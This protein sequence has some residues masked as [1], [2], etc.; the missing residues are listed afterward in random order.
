MRSIITKMPPVIKW[1]LKL[2]LVF[3]ASMTVFRFIFFLRYATDADKFSGSA[4]I[5]GLRFDVKFTSIFTLAFLL[6]TAIPYLNPFKHAGARKFWNIFLTVVYLL[7]VV[8][9]V[10]DYFHYDYLHQRLNANVLSYTQDAAISGNMVLQSYPVFSTALILIATIVLSLWLF[11]RILRKEQAYYNYKPKKVYLWNIVFFLLLGVSIFG[12]LGQYPL[13]WSDAFSLSNDFKA[14]VALNPIQS[15]FSTLRFKDNKP[16]MKLVK[17][18]YPLMADYLGVQHPDVATLNYKREYTFEDNG[19]KPNVVLVIC[20]SFSMYKSSMSGNPLN[21][22][23]FFN[24]M[25]DNGVFFDR[26]FTPAYGTARGVWATVTGIPDVLGTSKQTASRN[27]AAVDQHI[28]INDFKGY[29]RFYFLGGDPTW[30][31]IQG[32]LKNNIEDL[33]LYSQDDFKAKKVDVWGISD[34]HLFLEAN[35]ILAKQQ[36]P[37]FAI[38]QTADN[39]RPYTIPEEDLGQ[40]KKVSFPKDSLKKYGFENNDELNAFRYTDFCYQTFIEAA[41]KE[42]YFNNTIFVF[43]G[44]HGIR[45]DIGVVYPKAWT[46][47]GLSAEHV[48]LLFYSPKYL[49]PKRYDKICSQI[50]ILPSIASIA[51]VSYTNSALGRNLFDSTLQSHTA[52]IMD[53]DERSI[54]MLNDDYFFLKNLTSSKNEFVSVKDNT[55]V[56]PSAVSDS[57]KQYLHQLADAFYHTSKYLILN[58]KKSTK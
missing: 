35:T 53:H 52:F 56:P 47:Q 54:G 4:F 12:K 31:N 22:T 50:D 5:M 46:E 21:T 14:H 36:K 10:V 45:G 48:P 41:Q 7:L 57:M 32:L 9:Y 1:L 17:E 28:I 39:H 11:N 25:C 40:F 24:K 19:N 6:L 29:D 15:F 58:N 2:Y 16:D 13:R 30:A 37:F 3:L 44:D 23:P 18:Y 49:Q 38:I 8:F 33:K 20:E 51:K 26:C 27:P 34:K 43:V 55:A 42:P